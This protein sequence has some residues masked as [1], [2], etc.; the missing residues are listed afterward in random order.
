MSGHLVQ[1]HFS[2]HYFNLYNLSCSNFQM[3]A[4]S[5]CYILDLNRTI[6]SW[7]TNECWTK[8][9]ASRGASWWL[10]GVLCKL[11]N[12]EI[13]KSINDGTFFHGKNSIFG[14]SIDFFSFSGAFLQTGSDYKLMSGNVV[15]KFNL[16][17]RFGKSGIICSSRFWISFLGTLTAIFALKAHIWRSNLYS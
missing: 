12:P 4:L 10:Q 5:S 3:S 16:K 8:F 11:P 7:K 14:G 2:S 15:R 1:W 9:Q 13:E 6:T 17:L